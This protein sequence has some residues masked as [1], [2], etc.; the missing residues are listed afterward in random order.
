M[1]KLLTGSLM[2]ALSAF[3]FFSHAEF[4]ENMPDWVPAKVEDM[5]DGTCSLYS[6]NEDV[7]EVSKDACEA[8]G[9][10]RYDANLAAP[11]LDE[12]CYAKPG[13]V[14][15]KYSFV[16]VGDSTQR[17]RVNCKSGTTYSSDKKTMSTYRPYAA[18][19]IHS[20]PPDD[21]PDYK[22]GVD[23]DSDGNVDQCYPISPI[24]PLGYHKYSVEPYGCVPVECPSKGSASSSISAFGKIPVGGS[25]TYCDGTCSYSVNGDSVS[26]AG[27]K[28]ATGVSNGAV[29]G[30]GKVASN[31]GFTP[32]DKEGDCT[33]HTLSNGQL[34]QD[35]SNVTVPDDGTGDNNGGGEETGT[36]HEDN[37]VDE[38]ETDTPF[39][40]QD[41]GLVDDKEV[42]FNKNITDALEAQTESDKKAAAE[43]HNKLVEQQKE[44]S[45]YVERKAGERETARSSD[46][47]Q[48]ITQLDGIRQAIETGGT[49]GGGGSNQGVID[50][51]GDLS[52]GLGETDVETDSEPSAGIE[53]FYEPEY[54][55]GFQDVWSKNKTLI[56]QTEM[57]TYLN[58]WKVTASGQAPDFQLCFDLG[59]SMNFGCKSFELDPRLFPFLRIIILVST[60]FLCRALV[61][62]G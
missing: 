34:Y 18:E 61:F 40:P 29:C 10:A 54:P 3:S 55:N 36:D 48:M 51:I 37:L 47:T 13:Y 41:C 7:F 16:V 62:G 52:D 20:C 12:Q 50:A 5:S 17:W 56:D 11:Y 38:N 39:V 42:C 32:Q 9:R 21:F 28:W 26:H 25:G 49:G 58:T 31:A 6:P 15:Y 53:S 43:R 1:F 4:N 22:K 44:I 2:L 46:A 23:S 33:T 24:C 59:A 30:N 8:L 19:Y 45:D 14:A 57:M 60:A 35:C 27:S